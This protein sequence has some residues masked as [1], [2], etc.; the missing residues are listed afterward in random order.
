MAKN[1]ISCRWVAVGM[2]ERGYWRTSYLST[3]WGLK[4]N[5]GK[6]LECSGHLSKIHESE[7]HKRIFD[8]MKWMTIGLQQ[9]VSLEKENK[10]DS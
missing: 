4:Q 5:F 8:K 10:H 6:S 3:G 7:K 9:S 2:K 1:R